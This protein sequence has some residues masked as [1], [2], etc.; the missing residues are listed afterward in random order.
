MPISRLL[1]MIGLG[2]IAPTLGTHDA[3][4]AD[5]YQGKTLTVIA[6]FAPGGGVDTIA[7]VVTRHL[8]RF[9]PGNPSITVQN[10]EG[11]GG[12]VAANHVAQRPAPDGLTLAFPGRDHFVGAIVKVPGVAF[13]PVTLT[14]IGSPGSTNSAAYLRAATGLKTF[15]ELKTSGRTVTFGALAAT[16]YTAMVPTLLALTGAPIKVILGYGSTARVLLALEQGE[17]D[18]CYTSGDGIAN[19]PAVAKQ[20]VPIVQSAPSYPGLP[21]VRDVV[22]PEHRALA[23][24][25]LASDSFGVPM[26]GPPGIPAERTAI[27]RKAFIAMAQDQDYQAD[28]RRSLRDLAVSNPIEGGKL[29][30]MMRELVDAITPAVIADYRRLAAGK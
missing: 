25:V 5:F 23:D 7:R 9:I 15:D 12:I 3:F 27:L 21:L 19:R 6:G 11:A 1:A 8:G 20:V 30:A 13:D 28:A 4:A 29:A 26:V 10:M 17:I 22:R 2:V 14:Y 18:G 16:T 24:L